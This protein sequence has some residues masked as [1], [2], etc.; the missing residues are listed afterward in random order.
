MATG[1]LGRV[2]HNLRRAALLR[3]SGEVSDGALLGA[4]IQG[5]DPAAIEALVRRHGPMVLGVCR[6]VLGNVHDAEDAFQATFLVLLR[7]AASIVPREAVGNWL[8]G[9]AHRTALE[10]RRA[11]ARRGTRERQAAQMPHPPVEPVEKWPELQPL[12][13]RELSRLPD[14]YRLP[15]V[16]CDLEGRTRR[17][18]ARLLGIPDG[19]LSNR[20]AAARRLLAERLR[21]QGL[22]LSAAALAA[23]LAQ[24]TALAG[25]PSALV[26][27]T[28][29][30]A[31][32][33][34]ARG[35]AAAVSARVA[36]LSERVLKAMFLSKLKAASGLLLLAALLGI[37][38]AAGGLAGGAPAAGSGQPRDK[39]EARDGK[40]APPRK[41][42]RDEPPADEKW[43]DR[44]AL[45]EPKGLFTG[46]AFSP[47]GKT[48]ATPSGGFVHLWDLDKQEMRAT[49]SA[50]HSGYASVAFSP[51]S[52]T[53]ATIGPDVVVKLW[54]VDTGKERRSWK[55]LDKPAG[56]KPDLVG[57]NQLA[58]APDGKV[59]AAACGNSVKILDANTGKELATLDGHSDQVR[60][61]AFPRDGKVLVTGSADGTVKIWDVAAR[62]EKASMKSLKDGNF[63]LSSDG[64]TLA[65]VRPNDRTVILWDVATGTERVTW[66]EM[67]GN[68]LAFSPNGKMLAVGF[69]R[70][71]KI[72]DVANGKELAVLQRFA[73]TEEVICT[74]LAFSPDGKV[75][76]ASGFE[77]DLKTDNPIAGV[78]QLWELR[79]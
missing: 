75:L 30:A 71:V 41:D 21:S 25:V 78:L 11:A 22:T 59:L 18:V 64:K 53:V 51:D 42:A 56:E 31:M 12:L 9:V 61:I 36:V 63:A 46:V 74:S 14:R 4:F 48:V 40:A 49:L 13:D 60:T 72:C 3:N 29:Q 38:T 43:Q 70:Q 17:E 45:K 24:R 10:A 73:S 28:V 26:A 66:K 34:A 37:T 15:V 32:D 68:H 79:K 54:D 7:K 57:I 44:A 33:V 50:T 67:G 65:T 20:L 58:F 6:R 76:A 52:K 2:I 62:K 69:T 8:Y 47:D 35:T 55:L 5:R 23:F 1:P 77:W 27:S 39:G 16:L 19:T